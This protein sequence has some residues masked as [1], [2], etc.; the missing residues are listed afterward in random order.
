LAV[1]R[2]SALDAAFP[3]YY[4]AISGQPLSHRDAEFVDAIHTDTFFVGVPYRVGHADFYPNNGELQSGC[5]DLHALDGI[6]S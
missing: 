4:P 2:I 6:N 3:F 1:H 5:P